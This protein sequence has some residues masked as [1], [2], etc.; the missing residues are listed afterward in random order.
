MIKNFNII[1]KGVGGQGIVTLVAIIDQAAFLDGYD[2]RSSELHGLSQREGS[3][4][5]HVKFGKKVYSPLVYKGQADLIIGQEL[6]E[7]LRSVALAGAQTKFLINTFFSP[8][9]GSIK[10]QEALDEL[11]KLPKDKLVLVS[12]SKVCLEKLDKEVVSSIYLLGYAVGKKIM[13][14][15][16]ES[17]LQAIKSVIPEKHLEINIKAFELGYGN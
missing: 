12:A 9:I 15:K 7:G 11:N 17:V 6:L 13:P 16:K 8:F 14:L 10:E 5:A 1:I 2:V 3:V 4:E